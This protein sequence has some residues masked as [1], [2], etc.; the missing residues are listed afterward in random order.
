MREQVLDDNHPD[1]ATSL[2]ALAGLYQEMGRYA[3]AEPLYRRSLAIRERA[4]GP[5]HPHVAVTLNLLSFLHILQGNPAE[6]ETAARRALAIQERVFG[7][8]HPS[9][10]GTLVHLGAAYLAQGRHA[11]GEAALARALAIRESV[12]PE[13]HPDMATQSRGARPRLLCPAPLRRRR[14]LVQAGR[15]GERSRA[16]SA[17]PRHG[18]RAE[19]RR[20]RHHGAGQDGRRPGVFAPRDRRC[21]RAR[22]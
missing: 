2:S 18:G 22:A 7:N 4:L 8:S 6:G 5:E 19:P 20:D 13:N 10:A 3:D 12:L 14:A 9:V 11:E 1:I 15:R 16:G 17:S 21:H